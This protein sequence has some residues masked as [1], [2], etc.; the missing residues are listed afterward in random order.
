MC[1]KIVEFTGDAWQSPIAKIA[2][3][4]V[5]APAF[6]GNRKIGQVD[7]QRPILIADTASEVQAVSHGYQGGQSVIRQRR[8][9]VDDS[10]MQVPV[11]VDFVSHAKF[12]GPGIFPA[13]LDGI[14]L[15]QVDSGNSLGLIA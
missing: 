11:P 6:T 7:V 2:N 5:E 10:R 13:G 15:G 8:W 14:A 4:I 1:R 9:I 3:F 12:A